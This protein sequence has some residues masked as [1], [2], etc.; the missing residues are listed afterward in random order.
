MTISYNS[1]PH[2]ASQK[3]SG[4]IVRLDGRPI[5]IESVYEDGIV[6]FSTFTGQNRQCQLNELNLEPVPL[7]YINLRQNTVYGQRVPA[8]YYIQGLRQNN[9]LTRGRS[10]LGSPIHRSLALYNTICGIYPSLADCFESL[11][12][13]EGCQ[14]KAF[15]RKFALKRNGNRVRDLDLMYRDKKVGVVSQGSEGINY[16]LDSNK[17]YLQECLEEAINA[18]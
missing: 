13:R 16:R 6:S 14:S 7:G 1:D 18:N 11:V 3:L 10:R 8:R 15:S 9:F 4:S 5:Y 12:E 17:G 2:Y